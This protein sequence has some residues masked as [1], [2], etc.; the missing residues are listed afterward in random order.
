ML[1]SSGLMKR[2]LYKYAAIAARAI[3]CGS[4]TS[5]GY[6][7]SEQLPKR[8]RLYTHACPF[9]RACMC[10]QNCEVRTTT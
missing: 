9:A 3:S 4:M 10:V 5:A 7:G 6:C 8:T 1:Y 2:W